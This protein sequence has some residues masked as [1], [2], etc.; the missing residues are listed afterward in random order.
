[1]IVLRRQRN[2]DW[3]IE[4]QLAQEEPAERPLP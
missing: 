4:A 2:L 1:M 3:L